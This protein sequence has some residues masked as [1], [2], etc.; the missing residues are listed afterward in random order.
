LKVTGIIEAGIRVGPR[1]F[2]LVLSEQ[3]KE[4]VEGK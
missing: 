4:R 1:E 2:G 3:K